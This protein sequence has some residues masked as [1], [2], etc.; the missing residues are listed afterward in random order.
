MIDGEVQGQ[1]SQYIDVA[2]AKE[3]LTPEA[4]EFCKTSLHRAHS[5]RKVFYFTN[6]KGESTVGCAI[7]DPDQVERYENQMYPKN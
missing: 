1:M 6:G 2:R 4:F 3:I 5:E 7:V